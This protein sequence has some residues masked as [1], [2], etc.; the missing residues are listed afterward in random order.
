MSGPCGL[1]VVPNL[2]RQLVR[3]LVRKLVSEVILIGKR[4]VGEAKG[5]FHRRLGP[6]LVIAEVI[7][8]RER[9]LVVGRLVFFELGEF[10]R[11]IGVE[12]GEGVRFVRLECVEP[13]L[14]RK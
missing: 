12:F 4:V 11:F 6:E 14:F 2:V 3:K 7:E 10:V 1:T 13:I 9:V 8:L 5:I